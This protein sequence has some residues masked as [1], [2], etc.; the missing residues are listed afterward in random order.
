MNT[1]KLDMIALEE[2]H[3][4]PLM[5]TKDTKSLTKQQLFDGARRLVARIQQEAEPVAE[6]APSKD[7]SGVMSVNWSGAA[8]VGRLMFGDNLYAFPPAQPAQSAAVPA[9]WQAVPRCM[10]PAMR[11]LLL[12][13]DEFTTDEMWIMLLAAAPARPVGGEGEAK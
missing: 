1:D 8:S 5:G 12:R 7:G 9:G 4:D 3:F 10:T 11:E 6:V 2:F 13:A